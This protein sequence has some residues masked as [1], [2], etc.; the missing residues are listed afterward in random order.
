MLTNA[1]K[2]CKYINSSKIQIQVSKSLLFSFEIE[3]DF[4]DLDVPLMNLKIININNPKKTKQ[5]NFNEKD[6]KL[7]KKWLN[8]LHNDT[9]GVKK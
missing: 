4:P 1:R 9:K 7:L 6:Q 5:F 2:V 8:W 3:P